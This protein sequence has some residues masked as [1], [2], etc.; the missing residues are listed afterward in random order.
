MLEGISCRWREGEVIKEDLQD[1]ELANSYEEVRLFLQ[2]ALSGYPNQG[3]RILAV[4]RSREGSE[5]GREELP[6]LG[7]SY[8]KSTLP[9]SR[10][11]S[12]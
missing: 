4:T 11:G 7:R 8:F 9:R 12:P 5:K 2:E 6:A 1:A 3:I 10:E